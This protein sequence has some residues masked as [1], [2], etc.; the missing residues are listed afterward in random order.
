[1]NFKVEYWAK[2]EVSMNY[3]AKYKNGSVIAMFWNLADA[4]AYAESTLREGGKIIDLN[5]GATVYVK[6]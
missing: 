1:L 2:E 5:T 3:A 6:P 4:R